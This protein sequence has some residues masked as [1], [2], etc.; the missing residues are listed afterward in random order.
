[1]LESEAFVQK[2]KVTVAAEVKAVLDSWVR[3]EQQMKESEQAELTKSVIEKVMA[4]IKDEKTQREILA[5]AVA[6]VERKHSPPSDLIHLTHTFFRTGQGEGYL[7]VGSLRIS[8]TFV[9]AA[10]FYPE[11]PHRTRVMAKKF[12]RTNESAWLRDRMLPGNFT[13]VI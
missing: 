13:K 5:G 1:M 6:E 10:Q 4:S 11:Q 9:E 3:Y 2:Q 8:F 12:R 7:D